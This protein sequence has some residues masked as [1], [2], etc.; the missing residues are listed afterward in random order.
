MRR[1]P[2]VIDI[3]HREVT[4]TVDSSYGA[5]LPPLLISM[6]LRGASAC[7]Y[8][9]HPEAL[10]LRDALDELATQQIALAA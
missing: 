5:P 4:L 2:I 1:G 6:N 10:D 8:L 9:T 3:V 7:C